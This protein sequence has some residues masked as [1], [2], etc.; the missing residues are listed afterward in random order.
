M[1]LNLTDNAM[2]L[3]KKRYLQTDEE[4]NAIETPEQLFWRVANAIAEAEK[5]EERKEW[6]KKYYSLMTSLAF[7][8]N[9]PTLMNAGTPLGQL[10][11]CYVLPVPDSIE[12]IYGAVAKAAM[13]HKSGGGT[14]FSFSSLRQAGAYVKGTGK[15]SSGP[16]PFIKVFDEATNAIKQGGKR[17]GANMGLLRVDHPDIEKF[18]VAKNKEGEYSNFNFSV[19]ITREFMR[20]FAN[21]EDYAL[22]EPHTGKTVRKLNARAVFE[23][24]VYQAWKNGEPGVIFLDN[25]NAANPTPQLGN[26]EATNPCGEQPLLPNE[27]CNLGSVNLVKHVKVDSGEIDFEKLAETVRLAV[28]FLDNVITVN[29]Y[30]LPEIK[31]QTLKTRKI[32]LGVMGFADMLTML[33]V[34]YSAPK[35]QEI[36]EEV[37]GFINRT[38]HQASVDLAAERG[39]FPAWE[40][41]LWQEKG[42]K[43]R[44]A[45]VTTIAPTG[46]ISMLAGV[47]SGIE[48]IFGLTTISKRVDQEFI[49]INSAFER[50]ARARGFWRDSLPQEILDNGGSCR[51]IKGVPK[52]VEQVFEI[53][54]EIDPEVHVRM[55]AAFQRHTENAVSKTVNLPNSA[56]VEDVKKIYLLAYELGLKGTTVYRDG[57]RQS[58]VL[59]TSASKKVEAVAAVP[60]NI[61]PRPRGKRLFGVTTSWKTGCGS[62]FITT[63]KDEHG[64]AE[65]FARTGKRGGCPSQ[66]IAI[67]RLASIAL[68]SGVDPKEIIDQLRGIRCP[69]CLRAN[70]KSEVL[71]CPD[72]IGREL[73]YALQQEE[74]NKEIAV[75]AEP[76]KNVGNTDY[77]ECPECGLRTLQPD[78]GCVV[79][80]NCGYSKCG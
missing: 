67:G 7:L 31:E 16:L 8:P 12:G 24:I 1:S 40:G 77:D 20:A 70:G 13:I 61:K 41:S 68:R 46:S 15:F 23:K 78:G 48:P 5:K 42:I 25:I 11:A 33:G 71:S 69:S 53:S 47:S 21:G 51:G 59:N 26:I 44:N 14:G 10:A 74:I 32:G 66:S 57:S 34:P 39:V 64:I 45:T 29:K 54:A 37:M 35:A 50:V 73:E 38:A 18:I 3:L 80:T 58:Q 22:V 72:A 75:A 9:S 4:G 43:R 6:A 62:M 17:K 36:A 19:G 63:N 27:C 30:P 79:C 52:D 28:R 55:Q 65:V 49:E 56:T 76:V 60:K 2:T